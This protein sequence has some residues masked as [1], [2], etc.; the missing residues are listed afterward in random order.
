MTTTKSFLEKL[1]T[2]QSLLKA[3]KNQMNKF[4]GYRYRSCE[5]IME[6]LKP[7][8]LQ[9]GLVLIMKDDIE[10]RWEPSTITSTNSDGEETNTESRI[11]QR[12]YVKATATLYNVDNMNEFLTTTAYAR[13]E[14][15]KKGMDW[16][17]LSWSSSS[18]ARKYCLNAMFLIDDT[19]DADTWNT[20][21]ADNKSF[22]E[23]KWEIQKAKSADSLSKVAKMITSSYNA[24][25]LSGD[26]QKELKELYNSK[27]K[28][29]KS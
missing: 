12:F 20:W 10:V 13:E 16:S 8:L 19:K 22:E 1:M 24:W 27:T 26:E 5:D 23:L 18:Y 29:L 21:S 25:A 6:A 2:V 9:E 4:G 11:Y 14:E 28:E 15:S 7:L 3:P 17:Q